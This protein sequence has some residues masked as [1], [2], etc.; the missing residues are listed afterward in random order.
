MRVRLRVYVLCGCFWPCSTSRHT[1]IHTH[2]THTRMC[3][4]AHKHTTTRVDARLGGTRSGH[5]HLTLLHKCSARVRA[6]R[7]HAKRKVARSSL[8]VKMHRAHIAHTVHF[9]CKSSKLSQAHSAHE[10]TALRAAGRMRARLCA[11][12]GRRPHLAAR[13]HSVS[14]R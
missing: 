7:A 4:H 13:F 9:L 3:E 5:A 1:H 2:A 6:L 11:P 10:H 12:R 14:L 8:L